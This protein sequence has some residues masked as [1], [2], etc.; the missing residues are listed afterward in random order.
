[1]KQPNARQA[2]TPATKAMSASRPNAGVATAACTLGAG[3]RAEQENSLGGVGSK[4][5]LGGGCD[6]HVNVAMQKAANESE[7]DMLRAFEKDLVFTNFDSN[8]S[9]RNKISKHYKKARAQND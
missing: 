1:M 2:R 7:V 6:H 5:G 3:H 8:V 9:V 4:L